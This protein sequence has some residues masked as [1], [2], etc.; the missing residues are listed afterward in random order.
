MSSSKQIHYSTDLAYEQ[1]LAQGIPVC[2]M[3]RSQNTQEVRLAG[4]WKQM[5]HINFYNPTNYPKHLDANPPLTI[6]KETD[7]FIEF[8]GNPVK[9]RNAF[10]SLNNFP[11]GITDLAYKDTVANKRVFGQV[12]N[13]RAVAPSF[14]EVVRMRDVVFMVCP[15]FERKTEVTEELWFLQ[16]TVYYTGVK[17]TDTFDGHQIIT[18]SVY[19]YSARPTEL[20]PFKCAMRT[21]LRWWSNLRH[22]DKTVVVNE[23]LTQTECD[24]DEADALLNECE[25]KMLP[26]RIVVTT[27]TDDRG[28]ALLVNKSVN[29]AFSY[30]KH[31]STASFSALRGC[32]GDEKFGVTELDELVSRGIAFKEELSARVFHPDRVERMNAKYDVEDWMDC[33]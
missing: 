26:V 12:F 8:N 28:D 14:A 15:T 4:S 11:H 13:G 1:L 30:Y 5:P 20:T 18:R 3:L 19:Y 21:S 2:S 25:K 17:H 7:T 27:K 31:I 22:G 10:F 23:D 32:V 29:G 6:H 24:Y 9:Y 33:V 16:H